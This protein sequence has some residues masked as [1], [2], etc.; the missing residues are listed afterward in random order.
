MAR[1]KASYHHL[2]F[3]RVFQIPLV[4]G[5]K[6]ILSAN[7]IQYNALELLPVHHDTSIE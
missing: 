6:W 7:Q 2:K 3:P 5:E 4:A 1:Q